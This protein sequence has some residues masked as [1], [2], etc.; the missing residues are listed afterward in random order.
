MDAVRIGDHEIESPFTIPSGIVTVTP[1]TLKLF[2]E[3]IPELGVLTTK[4]IGPVPKEGNVEPVFAEVSPGSYQN[5]VGLSNPGYEA[6]G[7][8]MRAVYPL[9]SF[10]MTSIFGADEEEFREIADGLKGVTDGFELNISCPHEKGA[11]VDVGRSIENAQRIVKAVK[12]AGKPVFVKVSPSFS[13]LGNYARAVKGAGADGITAIN[14]VGPETSQ[15]ISMGVGGIS[16]RRIKERGINCVRKI[17]EAVDLPIIA[18][19]GIESANDVRKYQEA[20]G[21]VFGIGSALTGLTTDGIREYFRVLAD[22]MEKGTDIAKEFLV[23]NV[24]MQYSPY[25]ISRIEMHDK[26]LKVFHLDDGIEAEPGQFVMAWIP[27]VGEKPFSLASNAP[28]TLAVRKVGKFTSALF[29]LGEGDEIQ[30][31]GPYGKAFP[32]PDDQVI[33]VGGGTGAAPLAFY[34]E[35]AVLEGREPLVFIGGKTGSQLLFKKLFNAYAQLAA[36]TEDGSY[37]EKGLVTDV[38][39]K[40]LSDGELDGS[41]F[42]NCGPE[43]MMVAAVAVE[44]EHTEEEMIYSSVE[45]YMKCGVGIC[46]S[47]S[48]DGYRSCVDGPAFPGVSSDLGRLVRGKDGRRL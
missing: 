46:G 14:T 21:N 47:C 20:G 6:F 34:A 5:A 7:D 25:K 4:S 35:K 27:G 19:G 30:V 32:V 17:R 31:R 9:G 23:E 3:K 18:M 44:S 22:D 43:G 41:Y 38:L 37:G 11:G 16:G 26:D 48:F 45:R 28:L 24:R 13:R 2:S 29:E 42:I 1:E 39:Q 8:D 40:R 10:L 33:L 15:V 36:A 12:G